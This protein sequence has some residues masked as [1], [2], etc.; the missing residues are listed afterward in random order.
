MPDAPLYY[1]GNEI[2]TH[3]AFKKQVLRYASLLEERVQAGQFVVIALND[4]PVLSALFLACIALGAVPVMVNPRLSAGQLRA[5]CVDCQASIFIGHEERYETVQNMLGELIP[6]PVLYMR[7]TSN[8]LDQDQDLDIFLMGGSERWNDF[9]LSAADSLCYLQYTSG[10]TGTPK[11][12]I[13]TR[14]TTLGFCQSFAGAHLKLRS[15]DRLYSVP[16]MFFGYGMGNSLF[17]P[18][19]SGAS[20]VLDER[21]PDPRAVAANLARYRPTVFMAVPAMYRALRADA[22]VLA[23]CVRIAFSA[24]ASLPAAEFRAWQ[25]RGVEICDGIGATEVGHVFLANAPGRARPGVTGL[26][27]PGYRCALLGEEG[28]AVTDAGGSGVLVVSGPGVSPGY[29]NSPRHG[30]AA[31]AGGTYR[32]GDLFL[33][34]EDGSYTYQGREDDKF[35]V[36]G[37]WVVPISVE[38]ALCD[39][40]PDV[41]E[42]VLVPSTREHDGAKPTLF[43]TLQPGGQALDKDGIDLWLRGSFES[44]H[45]PRRIVHLDAMPRNDNGKLVKHELIARAAALLGEEAHA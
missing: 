18:L 42:A 35:K 31:F 12:V 25:E 4:S 1:Y 41:A 19:F 36:N 40:F 13:H 14:A 29:W 20:A 38:R 2:V 8:Y 24:G 27:L 26:P 39:R 28:Q 30:D 16:K 3:G 34:N 21:W 44:H 15:E 9:H 43:I 32:T 5:I 23:S 17:F 33:L 22:A 7:S 6:Q 45:L 10:S 11:G 37:R